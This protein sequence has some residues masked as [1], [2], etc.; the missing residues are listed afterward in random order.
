MKWEKEM[1][2]RNESFQIIDLV[3]RQLRQDTK[4]LE[5]LDVGD[6]IYLEP[7]DSTTKEVYVPADVVLLGVQCQCH[8]VES[9]KTCGRCYISTQHLNGDTEVI[10]KQGHPTL[11]NRNNIDHLNYTGELVYDEPEDGLHQFNAKFIGK[12]V[13]S[14]TEELN[15]NNTNFIPRGSTMF[16]AQSVICLVVYVGRETKIGKMMDSKMNVK[17]RSISDL[18]L[19]KCFL[20]MIYLL[21]F[22]TL[23]FSCIFYAELGSSN[24]F[25][26]VIIDPTQKTFQTNYFGNVLIQSF[27]EL[28]YILPV[29]LLVTIEFLRI[30][31]A[32]KIEKDPKLMASMFANPHFTDDLGKV[33]HIV[34]DGKDIITTK[35]IEVKSL[36]VPYESYKVDIALLKGV[37]ASSDCSSERLHQLLISVVLISN[38]TSLTIQERNAEDSAFLDMAEQLGYVATIHNDSQTQSLNLLDLTYDVVEILSL[39]SKD[40]VLNGIITK[41]RQQNKDI[42]SYFIKGTRSQLEEY[43]DMSLTAGVTDFTHRGMSTSYFAS[44][45]L[46]KSE[47]ELLLNY[48][49]PQRQVARLTWVEKN[50]ELFKLKPQNMQMVGSVGM[51][52]K[53]NLKCKDLFMDFRSAG[54]KTI[55]LSQTTQECIASSCVEAGILTGDKMD[56]LLKFENLKS[57]ITAKIERKVNCVIVNGNVFAENTLRIP[58]LMGTLSQHYD[59]IVVSGVLF[60]SLIFASMIL[61]NLVFCKYAFF[62][63]MVKNPLASPSCRTLSLSSLSLLQCLT[64]VC[65]SCSA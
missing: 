9:G 24:L 10:T 35:E 52:N 56:H 5:D 12:F 63:V 25:Y 61:A 36:S 8:N 42:Y 44:G 59:R 30:L 43:M 55:I 29:T 20:S 21:G 17:G 38:S 53:V 19:D 39:H 13:G 3:K 15:F 31:Q 33:S 32:W 40:S 41:T 51:R 57:M 60:V 48:S 50:Q 49:K 64:L 27:V 65:S 18:A 2:E 28:Q 45:V 7:N 22:L 16:H 46:I 6:V 58:F 62:C 4:Y 54:L 1:N 23:L 47:V 37:L 14:K 26:G 34:L 11:M